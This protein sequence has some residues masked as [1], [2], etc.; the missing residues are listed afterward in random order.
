MTRMRWRR[1]DSVS[2]AAAIAAASAV[3]CRTFGRTTDHTGHSSRGD[4]QPQGRRSSTPRRHSQRN[5]PT[6]TTPGTS[7]STLA[8]MVVPLRPGPTIESTVVDVIGA[9]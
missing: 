9:N 1:E 8:R 6:L 7:P 4:P 3:P 2:W 5:S